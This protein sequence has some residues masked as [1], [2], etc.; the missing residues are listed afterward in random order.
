MIYLFL[1][2]GCIVFIGHLFKYRD[3]CGVPIYPLLMTNYVIALIMSFS[4]SPG[5]QVVLIP[6]G[7]M[8]LAATLGALFVLC[9]ALMNLV[10]TKIGVSLTISLSRLSLVI[11]TL[12][13]IVIFRE[14]VDLTQIIGL[15]IAFSIMP[16]SG[17]EIPDKSNLRRLVH[18]GLGW[19]ILLFVLFGM[20][21]FVFKLKSELYRTVDTNS[22][23]IWV[24]IAALLLTL[25]FIILRKSPVTWKAIGFGVVLGFVNYG[26]AFFFMQA[27][28]VLPGMLAYPVNGISII[29]F[30]TI[31]SALIWKERLRIHSYVFIAGALVSIW[32]LF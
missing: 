11:P 22:F 15:V 5:S 6:P 13:S 26:A 29:V 18:G 3:S 1:S 10:I 32:L 21:D 24:Y 30:T 28:D 19:G 25:M 14:A 17:D 7:A 16:F 12:G 27:V 23:L 4:L 8:V 2:I 20:N 31:T 9:Y